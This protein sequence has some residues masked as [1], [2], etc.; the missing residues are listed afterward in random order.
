M[1][2]LRDLP[3]YSTQFHPEMTASDLRE[4]LGVY[5]ESYIGGDEVERFPW[6]APSPIASSLLRRFLLTLL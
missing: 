6:V 3:V 2:R 1:L 5:A 4:R